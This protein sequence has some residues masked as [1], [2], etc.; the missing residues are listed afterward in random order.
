MKPRLEFLGERPV[1]SRP[2]WARELKLADLK[3]CADL[4]V[5]PP[6]GA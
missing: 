6:V 4:D 5:A 3:T 1:Q 2:P